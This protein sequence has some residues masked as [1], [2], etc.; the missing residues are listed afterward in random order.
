MLGLNHSKYLLIYS[1]QFSDLNKTCL[2]S[3]KF[4]V[5]VLEPGSASLE[6]ASFHRGLRTEDMPIAAL[7]FMI[8]LCVAACSDSAMAQGA[9]TGGTKD[10]APPT[11]VFP[12]RPRDEPP[13]L[14]AVPTKPY[15]AHGHHTGRSLLIYQSRTRRR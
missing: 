2:V 10:S 8:I 7:V 14:T 3:E 4:P 15:R 11:M 12:I 9:A 1:F 6:F 13:P 5:T